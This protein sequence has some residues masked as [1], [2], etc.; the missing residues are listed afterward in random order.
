MRIETRAPDW[1]D[2]DPTELEMPKVRVVAIHQG[3]YNTYLEQRIPPFVQSHP[4][5]C[6]KNLTSLEL[7]PLVEAAGIE[8]AD[9][10]AA[11]FCHPS[12]IASLEQFPADFLAALKSADTSALHAIAEQWA[13]EMSTPDY[14]HSIDGERLTEDWTTE[15]AMSLMQPITKLVQMQD[16]RQ[17]LYLLVEA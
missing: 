7:T 17:N 4:H 6:S 3:D 8:N 14:T 13:S 9:L 5:W 12:R 10:E 2:V 16:G 1:P 15:E 11:L